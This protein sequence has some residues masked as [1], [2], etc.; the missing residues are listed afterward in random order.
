MRPPSAST[1]T[2][3]L[4]RAAPTVALAAIAAAAGARLARRSGGGTRAALRAPLD[5]VRGRAAAEG[6]A[7]EQTYTCECGMEYRVSGI[8]RHRVYWPADAPE[9]APVL[10]DRCVRCEKPLPSGHG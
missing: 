4:G 5:R 6:P 9:D 7:P 1:S 10:G 8:D 3:W 2:R